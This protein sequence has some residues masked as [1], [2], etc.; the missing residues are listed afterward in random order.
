MQ[1]VIL[2]DLFQ[3]PEGSAATNRVYTYAKGLKE[4]DVNVHVV[5]F[6][7]DYVT[8]KHGVFEG[9]PYD[10]PFSQQKR[11]SYFLVRRWQKLV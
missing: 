8:Q 11:H 5:C 4:W 6:G 2:G 1:V 9:I 10:Y 7:S 3:F